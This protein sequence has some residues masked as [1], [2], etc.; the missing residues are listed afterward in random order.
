MLSTASPST[1]SG[2]QEP[3][4]RQGAYP[5]AT[6]TWVLAYKTGNGGKAKVVQ[7]AFNYMLSSKAQNV[8]PSLG[9]VPLKG[10]ILAKAAV[11]KIGQ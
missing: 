2:W 6:L 11:N 1:R 4:P 7:D 3:Q 10:D 9:F 5:I 8:A